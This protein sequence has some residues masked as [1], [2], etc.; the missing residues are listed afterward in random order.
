M[1]QGTPEI[2]RAFDA[3]A[4]LFVKELRLQDAQ[5]L[6]EQV[7]E[8]YKVPLPST[9]LQSP[10]PQSPAIPSTVLQSTN[11]SYATGNYSSSGQVNIK[12]T[13]LKLAQ[14][15]DLAGST[16]KAAETRRRSENF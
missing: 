3:L 1:L 4:D 14:V 15:Y 10:A 11:A 6:Y 12:Q 2:A 13:L 9:P 16:E 7:L 5:K 8:I